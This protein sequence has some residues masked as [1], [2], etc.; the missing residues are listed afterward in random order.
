[1][2]QGGP[3]TE[4]EKKRLESPAASAAGLATSGASFEAEPGQTMMSPRGGSAD[5]EQKNGLSRPL[6]ADFEAGEDVEKQLSGDASQPQYAAPGLVSPGNMALKRTLGL[7]T[8]DLMNVSRI[9]MTCPRE[10][11]GFALPGATYHAWVPFVFFSFATLLNWVVTFAFG[12]SWQEYGH[13]YYFTAAFVGSLLVQSCQGI[14][15]AELLEGSATAVAMECTGHLR[16]AIGLIAGWCGVSQAVLAHS[17]LR[18]GID[19]NAFAAN[20]YVISYR[21]LAGNTLPLGFLFFFVG[22]HEAWLDHTDPRFSVLLTLAVITTVFAISLTVFSWEAVSR[23]QRSTEI[24]F[25]ASVSLYGLLT[26]TAGALR[27]GAV[28]GWVAM[29]SC[30]DRPA[31]TAP[32]AVLA[33]GGYYAYVTTAAKV[34]SW[35]P[36]FALT[37]ALI[38]SALVAIV[39]VEY[40]VLWEPRT[41]ESVTSGSLGSSQNAGRGTVEAAAAT[42]ATDEVTK[43]YFGG[44]HCFDSRAQV[45]HFGGGMAVASLCLA[46]LALLVD[47]QVGLKSCRRQSTCLISDRYDSLFGPKSEKREEVRFKGDFIL[48]S[49]A[50]GMDEEE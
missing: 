28:L 27:A 43:G 46:L 32:T 38:N 10:R 21:G 48:E 47:P 40:L 8:D 49:D 25:D 31:I 12:A 24:F 3:D 7:L 17:T 36:Q 20:Y 37:W 15:L 33:I 26:I 5:L 45:L 39:I 44:G 41:Q 4:V 2:K 30:V 18:H 34:N 23:N 35:S 14:H 22:V 19:S 13:R 9:D 6:S 42:A 50:D 29:L 16:G 1:M 11:A